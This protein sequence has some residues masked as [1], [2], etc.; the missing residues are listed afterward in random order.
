MLPGPSSE[1]LKG[2][3]AVG[4]RISVHRGRATTVQDLP[5]RDVVLDATGQ[6]NVR[7]Q[8]S[9]TTTADF[10]PRAPLDL[11]NNFGHRL[12]AWQVSQTPTGKVIET[13]LGFF[14]IEHWEETDGQMTIEAVDLTR[15]IETDVAA[16]PSSPPKNQRLQAELQRLAGDRVPVIL[17]STGNPLVDQTL[18]FQTDR[19]ANLADLALAHG[20]D[21]GMKPDGF[22]H[23]WPYTDA[24]VA[25]YSAEDLLLDAPRQSQDRKANHYLAVGSKTEGS[26]EAAKETR[27]SFEAK[28]TVPPFDED[29]GIVRDRIEV[30]AATD[31]AMVTNAA[32]AAQR[33]GAAVLGFRSFLIIPDP[34]LEYGDVCMFIAPDGPVKGRVTAFSM[35]VDRPGKMRVDAE[36][37]G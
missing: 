36:I 21:F 37:I 15:L 18:Q 19:L 33:Q 7:R 29:Y 3:L 12:H 16:W 25:T 5:V 6:R 4:A 26:G 8:L 11:V 32:N 10:I 34:R 20:L 14:H 28:L 31:Q 23:F 2:S 9:V 27:W 13:D 35:P 30:Q 22:L 1:E 17:D 24:V